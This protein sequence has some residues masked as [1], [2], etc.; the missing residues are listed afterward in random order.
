MMKYTVLAVLEQ[1]EDKI[2]YPDTLMIPSDEFRHNSNVVHGIHCLFSAVIFFFN[3]F[4]PFG[5]SEEWN[6]YFVLSI[7]SL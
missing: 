1:T 5:S 4:S 7:C 6:K 2:I 3:S